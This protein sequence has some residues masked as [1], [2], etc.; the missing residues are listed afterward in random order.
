LVPF[1]DG[2]NQESSSES[3]NAYYGMYIFGNAVN[4]NNIKNLGALG[5]AEEIRSIKKYYHIQLPQTNPVYNPVYTNKLRI[6]TN[7]FSAAMDGKTFFGTTSYTVH[8][9]HIIPVIPATEQLWSYNYSKDIFD[10]A[11]YGLRFSQAF[12]PGNTNVNV[13]QWTT[14]CMAAQ[15]IA[16]PQ[17]AWNFFPNYGYNTINYDNG[18]TQSAV[19]YWLLTR[20]HGVIGIEPINNIIPGKYSLSQNYPNPF[21]PATNIQFSIPL[22][23]FVKL[24]VYDVLGREAGNFINQ[25]L[26]PGTYKLDFDGRNLSS[27]TYF[28]RLEAGNF[29]DVKKMILIK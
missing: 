26:N 14:I 11:S 6:V 3:V 15:S 25:E 8:G 24:T 7:M 17:D 10:Y 20:L 13:W 5:L 19:V 12:D 23:S 1:G 18:T 28:Y 9:I 29:S 2:K 22:K 27:G 21:N 4:D 16:Y